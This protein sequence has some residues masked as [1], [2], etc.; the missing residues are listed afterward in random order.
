MLLA[1]YWHAELKDAQSSIVAQ[2]SNDNLHSQGQISLELAG[3]SGH[4]T[5]TKQKLKSG[6]R[7]PGKPSR[8]QVAA[9]EGPSED[10]L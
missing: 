7:M 10:F 9:A 4:L 3:R 1:I 5:P 8:K 2:W 6:S